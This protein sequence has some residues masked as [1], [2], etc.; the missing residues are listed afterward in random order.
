M[1]IWDIGKCQI[2]LR[3]IQNGKVY[4]VVVKDKITLTREKN[5]ASKL[6]CSILRDVITPECGNAVALTIDGYHNTFY[7]Y[8]VTTHKSKEWCDVECYDQLYYMN[9][10]KSR[11]SY[12]NATASEVA[13]RLCKDR[14]YGVL[15]PPQ[16]DD[17]EF[18]IPVRIEENVSDLTIITTALDLTYQHTAKR[19]FIWDDFGSITIHH[20]GKM[21]ASHNLLITRA[22]IENYSYD[23][24]LDDAYTASRVEEK[25]SGDN[26]SIKTYTAKDESAIEQLGFLEAFDTAQEGENPQNKANGLLQVNHAPV[27]TIQLSGVQGDCTIR[28][29]TPIL[30]DFFT[31]ERAEFIRAWFAVES[32]TH[33]FENGYHSMDLNCSM[34]VPLEDWGNTDPNYYSYP[35]GI[36]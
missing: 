19:F 13:Y 2:S 26:S 6:S 8:V 18:K 27:K 17:T 28:G 24:T 14:G 20:D 7:G 11:F 31:G 12:E 5:A 3:L 32:V 35:L 36:I 9:R 33:T 30:V 25:L 10:N 16:F 22:F 1:A 29:G 23:E 21:A 4:E 15:D 34:L